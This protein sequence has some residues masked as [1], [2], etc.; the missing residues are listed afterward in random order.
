MTGIICLDKPAG[1]TSF[2]AVGRLR[3]IIGEKKAGHAGTL[4]PF[5]TGAL[6]VAFGGCT[7]F[8]E[9]FPSHDKAYIAKMKLGLVTDTLDI[10]GTV[11]E[12]RAA[13][14][15][16][17][18]FLAATELFKGE[19]EQL[20]PM[21]SAVKKDGKRL[22]ELAR[23]GIEVEREKR[24][25]TVKTL[26]LISF[27]EL[28]QTAVISVECTAGTYIRSLACDIGE[29]LGCGAVLTELRRT[30]A[31]GFTQKDF[32]TL[33]QLE[34]LK[35]N[36]ELESAVVAID[37]ALGYEKVTVTKPQSVR[38]SNGGSLNIGRISA[39]KPGLYCVYSPEKEFLGV[40]EILPDAEEMTA[41]KVLPRG[42]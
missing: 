13:A 31:L 40:G 29:K 17:A 33:E 9:L 2:S 16:E 36:G 27:D 35:E 18:E 22:Y 26:E 8:L 12:E 28:S 41:R 14:V 5:A 15:S 10:T 4:D 24:N 30:A 39:K 37:R 6:P 21:Y 11:L 34:Q 19:I 23:Q 20:P 25:V 3:R 7:R 1:V 32:Y 38:F 42:V